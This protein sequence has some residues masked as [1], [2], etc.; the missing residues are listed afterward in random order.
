MLFWARTFYFLSKPRI[1]GKCSVFKVFK[2]NTAKHNNVIVQE[3]LSTIE[4]VQLFV[5]F[6]FRTA[7]CMGVVFSAM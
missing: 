5:G 3:L 6:N 7:D 4:I 1:S 2:I